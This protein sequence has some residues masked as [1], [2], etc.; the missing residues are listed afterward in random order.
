MVI[1]NFFVNPT[2]SSCS[3]VFLRIDKVRSPLTPP[4]SGTH[5]VKN[6]YD[7]FFVIDLEGK[8]VTI[9]I[10]RLKPAYEFSEEIPPRV[11]P[12]ANQSFSLAEKLLQ[13]ENTLSKNVRKTRYGRHV[14]FSKR[15]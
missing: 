11:S 7:K 2:L 6:Q 13:N 5:M 14:H 1:N 8:S 10:V 4:Y 12:K 9:T 3:H 15:L